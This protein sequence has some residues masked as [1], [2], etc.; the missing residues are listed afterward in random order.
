MK[1]TFSVLSIAFALLFA[2]L[3]VN[4]QTRG[5]IVGTVSD[6]NGG[7]VPN[8]AVSAVGADG[9]ALTA[10]TNEAGAFRIPSVGNGF[11]TVTVSANGFKKVVVSNV[12]VDVGLPTTVDATLQIGGIDQVVEV[13]SGGEILQ[14]ATAT[15]G[16]TI[17]GR[18]ITETPIASRDAL[19]LLLLLPGTNTVGAPRRS[20]INGLPKGALSIT[21]DG[22][23][24]QDNLLRSSDGYF[25]YVRPRIDA[26]D[27]V[28]VSTNN[29]GAESSGDGAVQIRFVTKR[30]TNDYTGGLYWQHRNTA[31]NSNYWYTNRDGVRDANGK[32]LR[33]RIILNQYGGKFGGPI[34]FPTFGAGDKMFDSGKNRAFF[35]VN[36]EEFRLPETR[37]VQ[38]TVLTPQA[39][40]GI[41][42]YITGSTVNTVNL[43]TLATAAGITNSA[44]PTIASVLQKIRSTLGKGTLSPITNNPNRNYFT[45]APASMS[46]RKF[47]ALRFDV[48]VNKSNS[49]E[50]VINR[51]KFLPSGADFL[52]SREPRFPGFAYYS[53]GS[54]RNSYSGAVRSTITKN[55]TNEARLAMSAGKSVF[56]PEASVAEFAFQGGYDLGFGTPLGITGATTN[57]STSARTTPTWDLTDSVTWIV[58]DHSVNF[59]GQ[60]KRIKAWSQAFNRMVPT[61]SFGMDTTDP[62]FSAFSTTSIPGATTT[63]LSEARSMWAGLVG[64]VTGYTATAYLGSNGQYSLNG[65]QIT[66][67]AQDTYG[68]YI[69]DSWR[70]RPE[71]TINYGIRWQPQGGYRILSANYAALSDPYM[72]YGLS[73]K[74]NIFKPG[75]TGGLVPT[76]KAVEKG[77]NATPD[78][79]N[80]LA[81]TI[82][83]VW[84]P[85]F[86]NKV[87]KSIF[88][89]SGKSVFRGGF[90]VAYVRE[91]TA[92]IGSI[93]GANPGGNQSA[94]RSLSIG[95]LTVGSLLRTSGNANLTAAAFPSTP[96]YPFTLTSANSAN[97]FDPEL[98]TG[99]VDSFSFGYQRELDVNSAIE[100]RYVGNRGRNLWRQHN[101]NEL[102]LIENNFG[103]EFRLAQANLYANIAAGRGANFSYYGAGTGT[104]PLPLIMAYINTAANYAPN[105]PTKYSASTA[106]LWANTTLVSYLSRNAPVAATFASALENNATRRAQA[107]AN[108]LPANFFYVNSSTLTG[109]AYWLDNSASSW[110]DSGV[111]EFRRR[112]SNG[113]RFQASYNFSKA[114][115]DSFQSNSDNFANYVHRSFGRT[116]AKNVA[117]FD[118]KHA[119]KF[120]AT[121]ELPFGKGKTYFGGANAVLDNIVGGWTLLPTVRWQSGSPFSFGNVQLVGMTKNE[122]QKAIGVYKNYNVVTFLPDDIIQMT[123]RAFD[124]NIAGTGGYGTT[125]GG[126][127]SGR[128]I[129]PAGYGNCISDYSGQCGF[130]NL[131]VYGPSFFNIDASLI[132]RVKISEKRNVE[133]RVTMLDALNRPNF[134]VGGWGSDTASSGVGGTTFGQ[135]ASGSAYQDVSTTNNPGGRMV[136]LSLRINF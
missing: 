78:D 59:G 127:P 67:S 126:A 48:N 12:K 92:L 41:F 55:I 111:I 83:V 36:Y 76:V 32:A 71:L 58:G 131:I 68:L 19:D 64:R 37:T 108:G 62:A 63:Q 26:I 6:P 45:W 99:R 134:R 29:P 87:L 125:Y 31:L 46:V 90:S 79:T 117:V 53:Q 35:F 77:S 86:D 17:T 136:D 74:G 23:D 110:Y 84:S 128:F 132:K 56:F 120:D 85:D 105:D 91:G 18:Q 93:L 121:Y 69:Q 97:A 61:V 38:R 60:Y 113:L 50:F 98:E 100:F 101:L 116:L 109:G 82:G 112:L 34:P 96:A 104:S 115:S 5:A 124:V 24:V 22:V 103:A 70:I 66:R 114:Q 2:G 130:N 129:A 1:R 33:Q 51:Q 49:V 75:S 25:T 81:P 16:Q 65:E 8:A 135:L 4:A 28:T 95:N 43:W 133:F 27:E 89:A 10:T 118:I 30:G 107:I 80:N 7:L 42:S 47:L 123:Q 52:N 94:S 21:I 39:E 102:N 57:N 106:T 44:D 15:I 122:L 9:K 88:G 14:T 20:S 119:L 73:G 11:Y 72:V 40:S 13:T 54:D 3:T